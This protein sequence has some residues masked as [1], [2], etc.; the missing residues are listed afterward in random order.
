VGRYFTELAFA[1]QLLGEMA[2]QEKDGVPFTEAQLDYIN[3]LIRVDKE[4]VVCAFVDHPNGWYARLFYISDSALE[5]D[6]TIADVHTQPADEGG[7]DVGRILHVATGM[8][9]LMVVTVNNCDGP[10]AYAGVVF[11]YFEKITENWLRMSDSEWNE[12][13]RDGGNPKDV[14]WMEDLVER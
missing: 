7:N 11:S 10:K 1:A 12:E 5:R 4:D 9:R 8:P 13:L 6:P 3:D 2:A 14:P